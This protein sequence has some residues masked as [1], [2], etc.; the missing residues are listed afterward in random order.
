MIHAY[1]LSDL[2]VEPDTIRQSLSNQPKTDTV[3]GHRGTSIL[4]TRTCFFL[5]ARSIELA[6]VSPSDE[7]EDEEDVQG[8]AD[9]DFEREVELDL[10]EDA[11]SEV[12]TQRK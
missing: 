10:D 6:E 3:L 1:A 11:I 7:V 2:L 4:S 9:G 5:R 12:L 8:D